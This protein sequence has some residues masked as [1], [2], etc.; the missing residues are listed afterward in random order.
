N[1]EKKDA[2]DLGNEDCE[3][4]STEEP[5]V[6]QEKDANIN[7]N[8]EDGVEADINNLETFMPISPIPTTIIHKDNPVEQII[9]DIY[10]APQTRRM[11]KN[12]TEQAV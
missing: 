2:E 7:N 11:P 6:N 12:V 4:P 3:V 1:E 10:L 9:G 5:R 8:D